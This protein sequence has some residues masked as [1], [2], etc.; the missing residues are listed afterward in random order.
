LQAELAAVGEALQALGG[1]G[2]AARPLS[3]PMS[4]QHRL[5]H[6]F[7]VDHAWTVWSTGEVA[8]RTGLPQSEALLRLAELAD[9][10]KV[11]RYGK[12][13]GTRWQA[14]SSR[15][16]WRSTPSPSGQPERP[17]GWAKI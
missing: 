9:Q 10:G 8:A 16:S 17:K 3:A 7:L 1:A 13:R 11:I 2:V 15:A 4:T 6:D 14:T 5:I 12:T